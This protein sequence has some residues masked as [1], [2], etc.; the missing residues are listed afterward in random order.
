MK[1]VN[2]I[3]K[4]PIKDSCDVFAAGGGVA[5]IATALAAA[6]EG[7][8]VILCEREYTLGGLATLGLITIYLPH[9]GR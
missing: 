5:G 2:E 1:T 9:G 6:R 7:A 3:K 8:K 4:T